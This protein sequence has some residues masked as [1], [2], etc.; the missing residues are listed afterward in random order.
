MVCSP[1]DR[2]LLPTCCLRLPRITRYG[3]R[4]VRTAAALPGETTMVGRAGDLCGRNAVQLGIIQNSLAGR[5]GAPN[6]INKQKLPANLLCN[7]HRCSFSSTT[8]VQT[9]TDSTLRNK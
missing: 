4:A 2:A 6:K 7:K 8:I 9:K 1:V 3:L 5:A